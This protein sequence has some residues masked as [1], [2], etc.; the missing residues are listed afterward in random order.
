MM[1]STSHVQHGDAEKGSSMGWAQFNIRLQL[2][3]SQE[4][5]ADFGLFKA[6]AE[7]LAA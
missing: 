4:L 7:P 6:F 3:N 2:F 1:G 5:S